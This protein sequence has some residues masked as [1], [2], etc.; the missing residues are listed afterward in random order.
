MVDENYHKEYRKNYDEKVKYVT[1]SIPISEYK[2][3]EKLAKKEKIKVSKLVKNMTIAYMQTKTL[4]P[5]GVEERLTEFVFLMR[6]SANNIN[7]IA[8][9][10]N[11]LKTLVDENGLFME[12]KKMEDLVRNFT[13]EKF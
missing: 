10:S 9:H 11:T 6:N 1:V 8:K 7:Q 12:L 2:E 5:N 13:L 4:I 3:L